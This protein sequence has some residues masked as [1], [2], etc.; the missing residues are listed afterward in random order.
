M[1]LLLLLLLFSTGDRVPLGV[2]HVLRNLNMHT[3]SWAE[4]KAV[5]PPPNLRYGHASVV[6]IGAGDDAVA[7]DEGGPAGAARVFYFGGYCGERSGA[8]DPLARRD[9]RFLDEVCLGGGCCRRS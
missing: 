5:G 6:V 4:L 1:L 2:L 8:R 7:D 9:E 3:P